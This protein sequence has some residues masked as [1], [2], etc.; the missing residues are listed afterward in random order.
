[1]GSAITF[2][3]DPLPYT[4]FSEFLKNKFFQSNRKVDDKVLEKAFQI[5]ENIPGD[6]QQLCGSIWEIT[7]EKEL[8]SIDKLKSA[9]EFGICQGTKVLRKLYPPSDKYSA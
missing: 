1:M 5:A 2:E 8:I 7:A 6:I 9:I 3:I 4:E